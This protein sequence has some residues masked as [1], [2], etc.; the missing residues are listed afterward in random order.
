MDSEK[1]TGI[2]ISRQPGKEEVSI[3][4]GGIKISA[5]EKPI[6]TSFVANWGWIYILLDCS[7][8]MRRGDKLDQAKLGIINFAKDAFKKEYRVG[9]I[10]FHDFAELLC[11]PTNNIDVIQAKIKDI[12]AVGGTNMTNAIKMAHD[13]LKDFTTARV[14]V[15]ATDGMPDNVK[16]SLAAADKAKADGIEILTIGT[17]DA[18]EEFLKKIASR[19][20]LGAKVASDKF[21]VAIS[22]ASLL[23]MSPK[24]LKPK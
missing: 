3:V 6:T 13:K 21:A 14:I 19:A 9:L 12:Q 23:L 10:K 17:D 8:S 22:D 4:A 20:E 16:N 2:Q 24:S 7:G 15:I 18:K 1:K 5:S 11:E